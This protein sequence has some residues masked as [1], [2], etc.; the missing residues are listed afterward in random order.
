[1]RHLPHAAAALLAQNFSPTTH[2][3]S[4]RNRIM[5]TRNLYQHYVVAMLVVL[6]SV[7]A[8]LLANAGANLQVLA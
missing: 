4:R 1:M 2:Q 8:G 5:N 6:V 7:T 3:S